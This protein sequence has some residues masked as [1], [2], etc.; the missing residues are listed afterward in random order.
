ADR[1]PGALELLDR[2][3]DATSRLGDV[4]DFRYVSM[5]RSHTA[6]YAGRLVEAEGDARAALEEVPGE[7]RRLNAPLA[8]AMLVDALVERG[9]LDEAHQVLE[10]YEIS[11]HQPTDTVI[12]HFIPMSRGRLRLR[13]NEPEAALVDL[14]EVGRFLVGA[15]Y[16][17]PGFAEWRTDAARAYVALDHPGAAADLAHENLELARAFGAPRSIARA[18]RTLA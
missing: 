15:G 17:N 12:M 13:R 11:D 6:W 3:L 5:L 18:L 7:P 8:A 1:T 14:L 2:G 10:D 4:W 9:R 16:V